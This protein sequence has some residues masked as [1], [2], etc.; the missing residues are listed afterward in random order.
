M[1]PH[2]QVAGFGRE[3]RQR[4]G[5]DGAGVEGEAGDGANGDGGEDGH[6]SGG[7]CP[8]KTNAPPQTPA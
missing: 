5:R 7:D 4:G 2:E 6:R 3:D 8:K 1:E